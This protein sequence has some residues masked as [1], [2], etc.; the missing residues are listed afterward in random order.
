MIAF[1]A[2]LAVASFGLG[3]LA[4]LLLWD[5]ATRADLR[6]VGR[7]E[8]ALDEYLDLEARQAESRGDWR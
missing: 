8:A 1:L 7:V 3:F 2:M 6:Q 5:R 4:C